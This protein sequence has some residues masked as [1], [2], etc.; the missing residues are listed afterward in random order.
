MEIK[1]KIKELEE[2]LK[3]IN[4]DSTE[5]LA[6]LTLLKKGVLEDGRLIMKSTGRFIPTIEEMLYGVYGK[7][8]FSLEEKQMLRDFAASH[9]INALEHAAEFANMQYDGN[10]NKLACTD[11][12]YVAGK[13]F[14]VNKDSI[15]KAYPLEFIT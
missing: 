13:T 8:E 1:N 14:R 9:V 4:E 2:D 11:S 6:K 15:L 7:K 10:P 3:K 5:K 12:F